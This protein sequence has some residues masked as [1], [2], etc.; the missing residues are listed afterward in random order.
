MSNARFRYP[1]CPSI[2]SNLTEPR[3]NI[4]VRHRYSIDYTST[5]RVP[6][7]FF[8]VP[9]DELNIARAL[10]THF[11]ESHFRTLFTRRVPES[12]H[13]PSARRLTVKRS[14]REREKHPC[15]TNCTR[16]QYPRIHTPQDGPPGGS[17]IS[18]RNENS[19]HVEQEPARRESAD[20]DRAER[21]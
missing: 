2:L 15:L 3:G 19:R 4:Y 18:P 5:G 20:N 7:R 21:P 11:L 8:R 16:Y 6:R 17:F 12:G 14:R 9:L 1:L 10:H 13:H